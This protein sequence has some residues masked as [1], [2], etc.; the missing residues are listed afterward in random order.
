VT[1]INLIVILL[2]VLVTALAQVCLKIGARLLDHEKLT[3]FNS[4]TIWYT[5]KLLFD[6]V[7][8]TGLTMYAASAI[9]WIWVLSRV[10]ISLAYPYVSLSFVITFVFGIWLFDEPVNAMKLIGTALIMCG[11]VLITKS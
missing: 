10:D 3:G 4:E 1:K 9:T 8:L 7:L 6:P 11:C 5:T 2:T